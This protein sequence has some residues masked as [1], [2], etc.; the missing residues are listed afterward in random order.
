MTDELEAGP[1]FSL[2]CAGIIAN[3]LSSVLAPAVEIAVMPERLKVDTES[4][5][6]RLEALRQK[7]L[8]EAKSTFSEGVPYSLEVKGMSEALTLIEWVCDCVRDQIGKG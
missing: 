6:N 7:L 4:A 5:A 3:I 1:E 2:E 8:R